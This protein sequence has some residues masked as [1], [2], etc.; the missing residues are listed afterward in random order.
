MMKRIRRKREPEMKEN[1][2]GK[3]NPKGKQDWERKGNP[4]G[5]DKLTAKVKPK[6]N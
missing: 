2:K 3:D 5:R 6:E 1:P 4:G